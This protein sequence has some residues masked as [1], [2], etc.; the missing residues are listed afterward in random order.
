M[1]QAVRE[2]HQAGLAQGLAQGEA[3]GR[4]KGEAV[5]REQALERVKSLTL[6][7]AKVEN[8]WPSLWETY[9]SLMTQLAVEAAEA[10]VNKEIE[11]GQ[12]LAAGAFRACVAYLSKAH[13]ATFRVN[14]ADLAELEA[15]RAETRGL[16][17]GLARVKFLPDPAMGPGDLVMESDVGRL[18]A[19]LKSR[20]EKVMTV[21]REALA[22]GLVAEPPEPAPSTPEVA[23]E[24]VAPEGAPVVGL[25]G[26]GPEVGPAPGAT[27]SAPGPLEP[28]PANQVA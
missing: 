26:L 23:P 27:P 17:D 9:G 3:E 24:I 19:T 22:Q 13:E 12:G 28:G 5:G 7:L 25:T 14:P 20:R 4:A 21:L 10:I 2:G 18:D 1:E 8:I 16:V 6:A 15:A 11:S